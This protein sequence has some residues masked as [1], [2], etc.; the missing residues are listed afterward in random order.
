MKLT[1]TKKTL[2]EIGTFVFIYILQL[3]ILSMSMVPNEAYG[4]K[5]IKVTA[6]PIPK[7]LSRTR[8]LKVNPMTA[9][10]IPAIND[11]SSFLFI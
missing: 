11:A 9:K 10:I 4:F 8:G 3:L 1:K 2:L 7:F 6:K 5:E